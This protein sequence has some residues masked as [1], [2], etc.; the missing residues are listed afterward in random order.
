MRDGDRKTNKK[1]VAIV[2]VKKLRG[3]KKPGAVE[4]WSRE[5]G[6]LKL[7]GPVT[8]WGRGENSVRLVQ[9]RR[10]EFGQKRRKDVLNTLHLK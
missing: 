3:R 10:C 7:S 6:E 1:T 5:M 8:G 4:T 9:K 2:C